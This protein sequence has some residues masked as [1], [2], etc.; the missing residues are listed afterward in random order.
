MAAEGC[1]AVVNKTETRL[2]GFE[3]VCPLS[4]LGAGVADDGKDGLAGIA[5]ITLRHAAAKL[6]A[7]RQET[8][9][10]QQLREEVVSDGADGVELDI[11]DGAADGVGNEGTH[12]GLV[13]ICDRILTGGA[14]QSD[15]TNGVGGK[16]LQGRSPF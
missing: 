10:H 4:E 13:N 1:S 3:G 16:G 5:V 8:A 6:F 14:G 15:H 7:V 2:F 11:V 9:A 12:Q